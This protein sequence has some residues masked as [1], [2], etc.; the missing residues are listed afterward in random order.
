M[1]TYDRGRAGLG[2]ELQPSGLLLEQPTA[3]ADSWPHWVGSIVTASLFPRP[4]GEADRFRERPAR[5]Q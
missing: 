5:Q 4:M 3:A 2:S 1:V